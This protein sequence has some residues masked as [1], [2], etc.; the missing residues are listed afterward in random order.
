MKNQNLELPKLP[1][2]RRAAGSFCQALGKSAGKFLAGVL[3]FQMLFLPVVGLTTKSAYARNQF[4]SSMETLKE[5]RAAYTHLGLN[6][7]I[8]RDLAKNDPVLNFYTSDEVS[9]VSSQILPEIHPSDSTIDEDPFL[10]RSQS[11]VA[12]DGDE[13]KLSLDAPLE[14]IFE[15]PDFFLFAVKPNSGFLE[16]VTDLVTGEKAYGIFVALKFEFQMAR[17]NY[18]PV[19]FYFFPLPEGAWDV[20]LPQAFE[21]PGTATLTLVDADGMALPIDYMDIHTLVKVGRMNLSA[22]RGIIGVDPHTLNPVYEKIPPRGST[23]GFGLRLVSTDQHP[24]SQD[25]A[26]RKGGLTQEEEL[27]YAKAKQKM[28]DNLVRVGTILGISL[29]AAVVLKYTVLKKKFQVLDPDTPPTQVKKSLRELR[30]IGDVYVHNLNTLSGIP[31]IWTA[32]ILENFFDRY[33]TKAAAAE[34]SLIRR[35]LNWGVFYSRNTASKMPLNTH[36]LLFGAVILGGIDTSFVYLQLDKATPWLGTTLGEIFPSQAEAAQAAFAPNNALTRM[37][38]DFELIRNIS[39]YATSGAATFS[40]DLQDIYEIPVHRMAVEELKRSGLDP[41]APQNVAKLEAAKEFYMNKILM[42]KGLP[43]KDRFLFDAGTVFE[44]INTVFAGLPNPVNNPEKYS[45]ALGAAPIK[46]DDNFWLAK[47]PGLLVPSLSKARD[48]ARE[49]MLEYPEDDSARHAFNLLDQLY[50]DV[51]ILRTYL[52]HPAQKLLGIAKNYHHV[53]HQIMLLSYEGTYRDM[54]VEGVRYIPQE[55][56]QKHSAGGASLAGNLFRRSLMSAMSGEEAMLNKSKENIGQFADAAVQAARS[57][58]ALSFQKEYQEIVRSSPEA[59]ESERIRKLIEA[60]PSEYEILLNDAA[61]QAKVLKEKLNA[62]Y[63]EP[64]FNWVER[65]Q[66]SRTRQTTHKAFK[67]ATGRNLDSSSLE[68][69]AL[70][71]KLFSQNLIRRLG[72]YFDYSVLPEGTEQKINKVADEA[73]AKKISEGLQT[74]KFLDSLKPEKRAEILAIWHAQFQVKDYLRL[75]NDPEAA[76][77]RSPARPGL[78]QNLR[79]TEVFRKN[80]RAGKILTGLARGAEAFF[81]T[82]SY[83]LGLTSKIYRVVPMAYDYVMTFKRI[84]RRLLMMYTAGY[85]FSYH[86]F[87]LTLS[88]SQL[89][90]WIMTSFPTLFAINPV[91]M[92]FFSNLHWKPM[93]QVWVMILYSTLWS[94]VSFFGSVPQY[95][96]QTWFDKQWK[97]AGVAIE[98][99]LTPI[100]DLGSSCL[101]GLGKI[102]NSR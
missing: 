70:W 34:N 93:G 24:D 84:S 51:H 85:A 66:I 73:L 35:F 37:L 47:R 41:N 15:G 50:K 17:A 87:G 18:S 56:V 100:K 88:Y 26:N 76:H 71:Q 42:A 75:M 78:L 31:S 33:F 45:D 96:Y 101:T 79:Q 74:K 5:F 32:N 30:Q 13:A 3:S 65:G 53:R 97:A 10:L 63:E 19:P 59:S 94:W 89:T 98:E 48:R 60:H 7:E 22:S 2:I 43:S 23:A 4:S 44:K 28:H 68:D 11:W 86:V 55:W 52:L 72:L 77:G 64:K 6:S 36:T 81:A 8:V 102:I 62:P 29:A 67:N 38:I 9:D 57:Q 80:N 12:G 14:F 21:N 92:R 83:E 49:L 20:D 58:L 90:W 82:D 91:F 61:L 25:P 39:G 40:R 46:S 54:Y 69:L 16:R 99:V 95:M 1:K 27:E